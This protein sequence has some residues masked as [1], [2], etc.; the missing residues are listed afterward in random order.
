MLA[1]YSHHLL[2]CVRHPRHA[3]RVPNIGSLPRAR[4]PAG[5]GRV[6]GVRR[7][8]AGRSAN[9]RGGLASGAVS[10]CRDR[11]RRPA[12]R[13]ERPHLL[14]SGGAGVASATVRIRPRREPGERGAPPRGR[15]TCAE[16]GRM[17]A[18]TVQTRRPASTP[19]PC[20]RVVRRSRA[21]TAV[22]WRRG[23]RRAASKS[24]PQ[25]Q[26][27]W[28]RQQQQQQQQPQTPVAIRQASC[29]RAPLRQHFSHRP[30]EKHGAL[31]GIRT[32]TMQ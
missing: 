24:R 3:P 8:P 27:Q 15:A 5:G 22:T 19:R 26:Q 28:Q 18:R 2:Y 30:G 12:P 32:R 1:T 31:A 23:C 7:R 13:R 29:R 25:W 4:D 20:S 11:P 17:P 14:S 9:G 10:P 6:I 21:S 16:R